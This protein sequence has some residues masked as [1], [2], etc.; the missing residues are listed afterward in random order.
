M[1]GDEVKSIRIENTMD[2]LRKIDRDMINDLAIQMAEI[3]GEMVHMNKNIEE[4]NT[5]F[6]EFRKEQRLINQAI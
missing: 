5:R 1:A 6:E 3:R 2:L 4:S